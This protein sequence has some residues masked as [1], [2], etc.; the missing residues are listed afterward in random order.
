MEWPAVSKDNV[1]C[2]SLVADFTNTTSALDF[3]V[4]IWKSATYDGTN[5]LPAADNFITSIFFQG[6]DARQ[7]GG[8]GLYYY[9]NEADFKLPIDYQDADNGSQLHVGL[10]N[11]D[12]ATTFHADDSIKIVFTVEP[13]L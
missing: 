10:V 11:R 13:M 3:E 6:T 4:F 7:I 8:A 12:G 5:L 1:D 9:E 2:V